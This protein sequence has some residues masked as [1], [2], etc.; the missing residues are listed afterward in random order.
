VSRP[1]QPTIS[2]TEFDLPTQVTNADGSSVT[3][4]YDAN[5]ARVRKVSTGSETISVGLYERRAQ[6]G[7]FTHVFYLPGGIGQIVFEAGGPCSTPEDCAPVYFHSDR[8]GTIDTLTSAGSVVGREKRDPFGRAYNPANLGGPDPFVTLGFIGQSEDAEIG[9]VNLNHRLYDSQTGRFI[10][11][12]PFVKDP[13]EGQEY[14]RY[15]YAAN[16]PLSFIDPDGLQSEPY[17]PPDLG[18][19]SIEFV[20][21]P[22][23]IDDTGSADA[24][25]DEDEFRTWVLSGD[26]APKASGE[27]LNPAT[28]VSSFTSLDSAQTP[29]MLPSFSSPP[30]PSQSF[31][32]QWQGR[33]ATG[34]GGGL[35]GLAPLIGTF[36]AIPGPP[37]PGPPDSSE[38]KR[39]VIERAFRWSATISGA[40]FGG[41]MGGAAAATDVVL[42]FTD[43]VGARGMTGVAVE[44]LAV[45]EA[46]IVPKLVLG[47]GQNPF[48]AASAGR[49]FVTEIGASATS[50][51]L[52][53]I[54]VFGAKQQFVIQMS[55]LTLLEQ[56]LRV[57]PEIASRSIFSIPG[58]TVVEGAFTLIRR[59]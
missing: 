18:G 45:G 37:L 30:T 48:L 31:A 28:P 43:A 50:R 44:S 24:V 49:I 20:E 51:Q 46:V 27:P 1:G 14:N 38:F 11:A 12:D 17:N 57:S 40:P 25:V 52:A 10:S 2:Y 35:V 53:Q 59:F 55:R 39:G 19:A 54:G 21:V 32:N 9:L 33:N 7:A 34:I 16:N 36:A 22:A 56:G 8:L 6:G 4:E 15:S 5:G 23:L 42:H 3:F 47:A 26:R 41:L 29:L 13:F 58:S